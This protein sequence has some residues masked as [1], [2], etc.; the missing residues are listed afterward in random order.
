[1]HAELRLGLGVRCGRKRVAR[2]M[3]QA[4]ICGIGHRR[5][6]GRR[7][8]APATHDDLVRRRF[9]A[10]EPVP[11][12]DLSDADDDD[13]SGHATRFSDRNLKGDIRPVPSGDLSDAD[14]D[15]GNRSAR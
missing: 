12:G 6:R 5:K 13:T 9:V 8:P 7:R 1:V 2:L 4:R 3:R 11:T 15:I 14:D 10:I